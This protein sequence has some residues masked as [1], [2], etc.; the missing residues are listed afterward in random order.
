MHGEDNTNPETCR[1]NQP[2]ILPTL[3]P[4]ITDRNIVDTRHRNEKVISMSFY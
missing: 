2:T 4:M 3:G 1:P